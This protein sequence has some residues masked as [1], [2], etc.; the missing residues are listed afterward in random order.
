MKRRPASRS[1]LSALL[2][3]T[4]ACGALT[5]PAAGQTAS[6]PAGAAA[7]QALLEKAHTLE[8]RGRLDMASQTWQQVL[9][10]DPNNT[11]ALAGLARASKVAGNNAL[12]NSYLER[13][14]AI[15]PNDPGIARAEKVSADQNNNSQLQQAGKFAQ[16]GQYAQAMAIYKKVF[17]DQPPAGDWALAYY[18]TE[19]ATEAGRPHAV[20]GLRGLVD[21]YPADS[22][23]QI[24]LG[25]ILT[26]NPRTRADGRR[27]LE[28]HPS[29]PQAMDAPPPVP[30]LGLR[31]PRLR[32]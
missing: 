21:K 26:Y 23:Y 27:Y 2:G 6:Q 19:A 14:K 28:R 16:A 30:H 31:Q 3:G 24:A 29:S 7:T 12:A 17:G 9:L 1:V 4:L 20:T 11:E 10:S 5:N 15:S 25:R 13:L 22:R 18:E 8:T 32:R